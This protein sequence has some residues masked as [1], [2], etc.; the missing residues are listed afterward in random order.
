MLNE[1]VTY[2]SGEDSCN[3]DSGG[4]LLAHDARSFK[5]PKYL[6]G[7]VSFGTKKCGIV[8]VLMNFESISNILNVFTFSGSTG[9]VY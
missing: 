4:P 6:L 5:E 3:G 2:I 1:I 7:I 8:I 9:S